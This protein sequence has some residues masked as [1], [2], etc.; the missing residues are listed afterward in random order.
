MWGNT[1]DTMESEGVYTKQRRIAELARIHKQVSF[2]SL[3]YH[4]DLEWMY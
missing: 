4:M 2:T 1:E 3:A